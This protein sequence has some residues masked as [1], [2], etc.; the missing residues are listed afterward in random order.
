MKLD[1]NA[2]RET[3]LQLV[4]QRLGY[5]PAARYVRTVEYHL[6][7]GRKIAITS[8]PG[9]SRSGGTLGMF[10]VWNGD[11][12]EPGKPGGAGAIDLVMTV[13]RR[14]F[15][16][17]L[18][19][20]AELIS[21]QGPEIQTTRKEADPTLPLFSRTTLPTRSDEA[22]PA[23]LR[24]LC[25]SRNLP[26]S[27][28]ESLIDE[29]VLYAHVHSYKVN[30]TS[31]SFTN[32]VFVMRADATGAPAGSMIRGCYDGRRPRK[33]TLPFE[34][35]AGATFWIGTKLEKAQTVVVAES[36]I[37]CLSWMALHPEH[38]QVHC[39]TYGGARWRHVRNILEQIKACG[40]RLV[41]A[42]NNDEEGNRA[43]AEFEKMAGAAGLS[44]IRDQ[45]QGVKDW[46]DVLRANQTP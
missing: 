18:G 21:T 34:N 16:A 43:A 26:R 17:A 35:G 25:K 5:E 33:S 20:L 30:E 10:Q 7:D 1:L 3:D 39:R 46:N 11:S 36:P 4:M 19:F 12:F 2:L 23:L 27:L 31:R 9:S 40:A 14:P 29:G 45:P 37:E 15:R 42:F 32:A 24:Y 6:P 44:V 8:H 13:T 22:L 28:V 41:C 38:D